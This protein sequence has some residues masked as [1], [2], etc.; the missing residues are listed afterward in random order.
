MGCTHVCKRS[1]T[2]N[3]LVQHDSWILA[4]QL[5]LN[6]KTPKFM[7]SYL[8]LPMYLFTIWIWW[9]NNLIK[10]PG[11]TSRGMSIWVLLSCK[12]LLPQKMQW[13]PG[14]DYPYQGERGTDILESMPAPWVHKEIQNTVCQPSHLKSWTAR[15]GMNLL[16]P[17]KPHINKPT[18]LP[19]LNLWRDG[20]KLKHV[21]QTA[22]Q[23]PSRHGTTL[24]S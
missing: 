9:T 21:G 2:L 18:K 22:N 11:T 12:V 5:T 3:S 1:N 15:H 10:N 14:A 7:A 8:L 19:N 4:K 23:V 17:K 16:Q 24:I 13:L 20:C 6:P